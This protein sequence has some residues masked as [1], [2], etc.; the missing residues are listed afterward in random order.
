MK[1]I[2]VGLVLGFALSGAA[3]AQVSVTPAN[4]TNV[5]TLVDEHFA[6]GGVV[7]RNAKFNGQT[8]VN[9]NQIGTFTNVTTTSPNIPV[10]SGIVLVTGVSSDAAAG[11][12]SGNESS[13]AEPASDG[14]GISI[15]L[16]NT[17][18]SQGNNQSMNDVAVLQFD[19]IPSGDRVSFKYSFASEEYPGFVCSSFNDV[20]GFYISGPYDE[21]GN[22]ASVPG[23]DNYQYR[24]IAVIPGSTDPVT[25]NTV[26][27]GTAAGNASPCIL[28]N[29][30]Y[31]ITN[32]N[33]NCRMNGYTTQL[34]TEQVY[35]APCYTYKLELAICDVGDHSYNSA[36]YLAANS[37]RVDEISLSNP[38]E[39][40]P[41]GGQTVVFT[42][43][44]SHYDLTMTLNRPAEGE[45]PYQLTFESQ[46]GAAEGEDY[47]L[48]DLNG[49]PVGTQLTIPDGQNEATVR[50]NFIANEN[51]A[52]GTIKT[53]RVIGPEFS[54]CSRR[55][56]VELQMETPPA[57]THIMQRKVED[58]YIELTD[59]IVYCE[60]V[61]PLNE[62][63]NIEVEGA[64]GEVTYQWSA[65]N[66][67]EESRN[68][69]P[70]AEPMTVFVTIED[71]CGRS[72]EDTVEF[73]V[74]TASTTASVDK[75]SICVGETVTLSTDEAVEYHWTSSPYD[76]SIAATANTREPEASPTV[77]TVY[78][79]EITDEYTCKAWA[80]VEV[81][82]IPPV[83][84][85]L[86]LSPA[87]TTVAD[88][89]IEYQDLTVGGF[90]RLWDFGDGQTSTLASGIV[91]YSSEDTATYNVMLIAYNEAL[92]PDTAY[93][94][95]QVTPEF[96]LW[97]PNSFTPASDDANACFG[98]TF[99]YE[100]EYELSI[101]SRNG[102]KIFQSSADAPKWDGKVNGKDYAPDGAYIYVLMYRENGLLKRKTGTVNLMLNTK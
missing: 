55:D 98:P 4:G 15:P 31:F 52:P 101:F 37:F 50:I 82:V 6:G 7:I 14:D 89:N 51:D 48:T 61:L 43:G 100:T 84:A 87:K 90:S 5:Q 91:N 92:C 102:D 2:L 74:N 35:V 80:S 26:N 65:G 56:T 63:L 67:A 93:G 16:T 83:K 96:T 33:N 28:T 99:G 70:V 8:T 71:A 49:N 81:K 60:N 38:N 79:V 11:S 1:R 64:V 94:T 78:T 40:T 18:R 72:I 53:L 41:E 25:I 77:T 54:E 42:K 24:N 13:S 12:S 69:I 75:E 36:V 47:T 66:H 19:F 20:F 32:A 10:A 9:S 88:P 85:A 68:L 86:R 29:T 59:D 58:G 39:G 57:F 34:E 17:L 76:M 3:V 23:F 73:R 95:V 21:N 27:G 44:C 97:L 22:P 46:D 62:D 30:Q 45:E